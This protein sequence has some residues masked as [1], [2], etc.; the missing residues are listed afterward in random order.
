MLINAL[1]EYYDIL[2]DQ[3]KLPRD[4]FCKQKIHYKILLNS[5]GGIDD[6]VNCQNEKKI[7]DKKGKE[8]TLYEPLNEIF[9]KRNQKPGIAAEIIDHR[10]KYIFGLTF[11]SKNDEF[12]L[13]AD[14]KS[15]KCLFDVF[16]ETNLE[17]IEDV[18][19][20][21]AS[22]YKKFIEN[23][24][25]N[26][27]LENPILHKIA[28]DFEKS[29]YSFAV[30][31]NPNVTLQSD[32][33]VKGK[34]EKL[35]SNKKSGEVIGTCSITGEKN[36][37]IARIHDNKIKGI[38]GGQASGC[39]FVG[40]NNPAEESYGKVQAYNSSISESCAEKYT[41]ALNYLLASNN[42]KMRIDDTTIVFWAQGESD[43]ECVGLLESLLDYNDDDIT[44]EDM[45]NNIK[46]IFEQIKEGKKPNFEGFETHENLMF[47]IAG[48]T[49]NN[50]R[51]SLRFVY[52]NTFGNILDGVCKHYEDMML[53][54]TTAP[55]PLWRIRRELV[56]PKS[57]NPKIPPSLTTGLFKSVLFGG[58]Y[59]MELLD[60]IVRRVKT[61]KYENTIRIGLLKACINRFK[62]KDVIKMGLDKN[63]TEPAYLCGRLFALLEFVQRKAAEPTKL[64]RTIKDAYI[65]AASANPSRVFPTILKLSEHHM[66]KLDK[67][68]YYE[69]IEGEI[70]EKFETHFPTT[71]DLV[72]QGTFYI[73]YYQQ[74]QSFYKK[75]EEEK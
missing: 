53:D 69:Q 14:K 60:T 12:T 58:K 49:P 20:P 9:P 61:D 51:I 35:Y 38:I 65:S 36:V 31:G 46:K 72:E 74:K 71:L 43:D 66:A 57:S 27:Q 39:V 32:S 54:E 73:G 62:G 25:P 70:L 28:R 13:A 42:H 7:K 26:E 1:T 63:N 15:N 45:N 4:G 23:W 75:N 55:I 5:D 22:A 19:T 10:P 30:S 59:P 37:P 40:T 34:W 8:K 24:T 48:V 67:S 3:G 18:N 17:F 64:N 21:I 11:D 6:I 16:K 47:Y 41:A 29:S 50:S 2:A 56:S 33:A 44:A 68:T 52:R